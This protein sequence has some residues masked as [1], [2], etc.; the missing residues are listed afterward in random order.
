MFQ[1]TGMPGRMNF[2]GGAPQAQ[3]NPEM[4]KNSLKNQAKALQV[5]MD[6][7]KNRLDALEAGTTSE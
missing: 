3:A 5:Q 2:R 6:L 7:I 1:A 4:E